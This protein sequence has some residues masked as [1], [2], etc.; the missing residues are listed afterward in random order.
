MAAE[1]AGSSV[2]GNATG[3]GTAVRT[4]EQGARPLALVTGGQRGIGRAIA[5]AFARGDHDVLVAD[6][7][8]ARTGSAL[9][10]DWGAAGRVECAIADVG[11]ER[12]VDGLFADA[13]ARFG[14]A[15]DVLV[16]NAAVQ[17]WSPLL[18]LS[19]ADW[20]TTLRVNLT[21]PFLMTRA[22]ANARLTAASE[23][24]HGRP[25][26][27]IVNIGSGC[28]RLAFPKLVS[29]TASKGGLEMLTKVSAL[30]LGEFGIR[31]NAILPGAIETERTRAETD[32]YGKAWG[33]LTPL[34]RAGTAEDVADAVVAL[35][36]EANRFVS[37]ESLAVDGGLF[38]RAA[39]PGTY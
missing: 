28:N 2:A 39:W 16:N 5:R 24:G 12:A 22:F 8:D 26:G 9:S 11:D 17:F 14:R 13:L 7:D 27:A 15:P 20:E 36:G 37:G 3:A 6:L 30:E 4:G 33:P 29:Y 21:G 35:A 32:G 23:R 18:A 10:M 19:L 34:G 38:S 31:V 1:T 25:G